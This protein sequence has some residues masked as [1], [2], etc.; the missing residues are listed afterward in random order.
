MR[1]Y[2]KAAPALPA[3]HATPNFPVAEQVAVSLREH[4]LSG[5]WRPGE[6][7]PPMTALAQVYGTSV[8]PVLQ[9][10]Q[11][12]RSEGLVTTRRGSGTYV[13]QDTSNRQRVIRVMLHYEALPQLLDEFSREHPNCK[14]ISIPWTDDEDEQVRLVES[15]R[16]P[17]LVSV[18]M[19]GFHELSYRKLLRPIDAVFPT[20]NDE[21]HTF[22]KMENVFQL[23]GQRF[24]VALGIDPFIPVA[25]RSVFKGAGEEL[26]SADWSGRE[27]ID[28]AIRLTRDANGDGVVDEFGYLITNRIPTWMVPFIGLG[29]SI[30]SWKAAQSDASR[31][32]IR[33]LWLAIYRDQISPRGIADGGPGRYGQA[34][35]IAA[36]T[37]RVA[38]M[39]AD[40]YSLRQCKA[41][42]GEDIAVLHSPR[43]PSGRRAS[44]V[45]VQGVAIP[46]KA[47]CPDG[48]M[49][50]IRFLRT[51]KAQK[52]LCEPAHILPIQLGLWE[53]MLDG[54]RA[55]AWTLLDE[56]AGA[57]PY[58]Y[59]DTPWE[60]YEVLRHLLRLLEG[61]ILPEEFDKV[62]AERAAAP[63]RGRKRFLKDGSEALEEEARTP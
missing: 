59:S 38:M 37:A 27:M 18:S 39:L 34:T 17:D 13:A 29:G 52:L 31:A 48:A 20:E 6:Q 53:E 9:A 21:E 43:M 44:L 54:D 62:L 45:S 12:L 24:G 2:E 41:R 47:L 19:E 10:V 51:P 33:T 61:R 63:C 5:G 58:N 16:P 15:A 1:P 42:Y 14:V 32:A 3:L 25:R 49:E 60:M 11:R 30:V 22:W 46:K 35:M 57:F 4:I 8:F 23:H 28:L 50:L 7:L 56:A 36:E 55:L 26:P 40:V